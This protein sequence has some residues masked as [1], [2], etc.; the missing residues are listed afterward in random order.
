MKNYKSNRM[1][2]AFA[3]AIAM[4][5]P[6]FALGQG[7]V[8]T[9]RANDASNRYGSGGRNTAWNSQNVNNNIYSQS[10]GNRIVTGNVTMGRE[11]RGNVGYSDPYGF[12]GVTGGSGMDNFVKNSSGV[13]QAYSR[14]APPNVSTP[15]YGPGSTVQQPAG[16]VYNST[17]GGYVPPA[18]TTGQRGFEDQ[19]LGVVNLNQPL[20]PLPSSGQLITRG[21]LNP[22]AG[23]QAGI[24][25]GS[26]LYGFREWN[27]ADPADRLFL[28]QILSRQNTTFDRMHL[29]PR[30][31]Q[32]MRDELNKALQGDTGEDAKQGTRERPVGL[33][34]LDPLGRVLES[35]ADPNLSGQPM[36][37]QLASAGLGTG[38]G[39]RYYVLGRARRSS[40]QYTEL[41]K[42]L[43]QYY[44]ERKKTDADFA[45]DFNQ[46]MRAKAAA[47]AKAKGGKVPGGAAPG[48]TVDNTVPKPPVDKVT[49]PDEATKPKKKPQPIKVN[50]LAAGVKAEGLSNVLKKAESLMKEGKYASAIDQYESAETVAPNNPLIWLGRANAELGAGYFGRADAHLRQAF[51][52]DKALLMGQYDIT[53]MLGEERLGKLVAELKEIAN[54]D[55]RPMAVFLLAYIAYNSGHERQAA[56]YLELATKRAGDKDLFLHMVKEHWALPDGTEAPKAPEKKADDKKPEQNK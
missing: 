12:R 11:F 6:V 49:T 21:T 25:T 31:V 53:G 10:N 46:Q 19:R 1:M 3:L 18:P 30:E 56:G 7:M 33:L 43:E 24:I 44:G 41:Q 55:D 52:T 39:T 4:F 16:Y 51:M 26:A 48:T 32:R 5:L 20:A 38:E 8:D 35:P 45:R 50:T 15:F 36:N 37:T 28:E 40:A 17:Q 42:R 34:S 29:D 14:E 13:P 9:G 47:E 22:Q 27:P 54:K 23:G 2:M